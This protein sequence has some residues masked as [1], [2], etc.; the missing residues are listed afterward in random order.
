[1][2][3]GETVEGKD[4]RGNKL[5]LV[6]DGTDGTGKCTRKRGVIKCDERGKEGNDGKRK[7]EGR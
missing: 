3:K 6:G 2:W 5:S 1:M 4:E 7:Q